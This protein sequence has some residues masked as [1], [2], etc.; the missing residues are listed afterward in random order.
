MSGLSDNPLIIATRHD[1]DGKYLYQLEVTRDDFDYLFRLCKCDLPF[2]KHISINRA[3]VLIQEAGSLSEAEAE[4]LERC[5]DC[6]EFLRSFVSVA[7]YVG[8]SVRFPRQE[9]CIDNDHAA[10]NCG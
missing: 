8:F 9:H 5:S 3:W 1:R 2:V 4:H 10:M 6:I 7:R